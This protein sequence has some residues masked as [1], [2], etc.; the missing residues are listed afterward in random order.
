MVKLLY[1]NQLY[2]TFENRS[3]DLFSKELAKEI[4]K[5]FGIGIFNDQAKTNEIL[6]FSYAWTADKFVELMHGQTDQRFFYYLFQ[7]HECS[8]RL[9]FKTLSSREDAQNNGVDINT[10][11]LNRRI[12]KL[13]LE[14]S[15]DINYV[16]PME[17]D[18]GMIP[19]FVQLVEDLMFLGDRLYGYAEF[20]AEQRMMEDPTEIIV[21]SEEMVVQ[22]KHHYDQVYSKMQDFF[23][24]GFIKGF[25]DE[26]IIKEL[27]GVLND[28]MGIDYDFA[29]SII[30]QIKEHFS[31]E[32][33]DMQTIQHYVMAANLTANGV[34]EAEAK[35]FYD[36][37]TL[38]RE[39]KLDIKDSVYKSNSLLRY[40]F[41]PILVVNINGDERTLVGK[42][43]W[44][45]SIMVMAT[46]G[47]QWQQ[48]PDEWK[49]NKSF[50]K[51]LEK[52]AR[53]HDVLLEK[54]VMIVLDK[55]G[56]PYIHHVLSLKPQKGQMVSVD[57]KPGEM[58]F[59]I[60]DLN[61]QKVLVTDCK[62]HRARYE[63]VGFS[64]DYKNFK[65]QYEEKI[66]KKVKFI[67]ENLQLVQ[68][69]FEGTGKLSGI[70]IAK[71]EVEALFIVNTPTFYVFNGKFN[72]IM[73]S[74]LDSF[75]D[76]NYKFPELTITPHD[77]TQPGKKIK[78]PYFTIQ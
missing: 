36:G 75:I 38:R 25:I 45:E 65:E 40:M 1:G 73:V 17:A 57:P 76:V 64:H 27:R 69:H 3:R 6:K 77:K 8:I 70:D 30:H 48:A 43:K 23:M 39:N 68:E 42:E 24:D 52:K 49:Q 13:A 26:D 72:A 21:T 37:L 32:A 66:E 14:Q 11:A 54:E 61:A 62:Y 59:I 33:P 19:G 55:K 53:E 5:E 35:R 12:L 7:V 10:L 20:M 46:N 74:H 47:F 29:G 31:P 18:Y 34:D 2:I 56:I 51:Y 63:M 78:H 15:C 9:Y 58:D 22:R 60:I 28:C 4:E 71:F 16:G 67:S 41:K 44:Q 50:N